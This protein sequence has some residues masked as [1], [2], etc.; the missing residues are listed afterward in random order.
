MRPFLRIASGA[1]IA[2][3][4]FYGSYDV[5]SS[6]A[7]STRTLCYAAVT[8]ADYKYVTRSTS[9]AEADRKTE[10]MAAM[11]QRAADRLLHVCMLH[12]GLY[13]K[14]GQF[15]ASMTHMMPDEI[16]RTMAACEDRASAVSF[17]VAKGAVEA[18]LQQPME[19]LFR[20]FDPTPIAAASLAQVHRAV[21]FDG[22]EVV[23]KVQY[24][25]LEVQMNADQRTLQLLSKL[26]ELCFPGCGYEWLLPEFEESMKQELDFTQEAANAKRASQMLADI[27][28]IYV[29][30]TLPQLSSSK[31]LTME[32][33]QGVK[34]TDEQAVNALQLS[35]SELVSLLVRAFSVMIF[36]GGFVHCDPHPG[37]LL[38]REDPTHCGRAQ[39]VLLDHG[40][41]RE[42]SAEFRNDYCELWYCLLTRA[43][44][45]GQ[46]AAAKLGVAPSDYDYLSLILTFR[47][48]SSLTALGSRMSN[49]ERSRLRKQMMQ[50][51]FA[52]VSGFFE[53]M[54]RDMLFVMRT[55][56]YVRS[57]NRALGGTTRNRIAVQGEHAVQGMVLANSS[58]SDSWTTVLVSQLRLTLMLWHIRL[59]MSL[60]DGFFRLL[61]L[62]RH[63]MHPEQRRRELG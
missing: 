18:A 10:A 47:P 4:G 15:M 44:S 22:Q 50:L 25:Q 35:R 60:F 16:T 52:D 43:H 13:T 11:R 5:H 39:L 58:M 2:A 63:T 51:R 37:N 49:E 55:W 9:E 42:L 24:P 1:S 30:R 26:V 48:A 12:G 32:Y 31:V 19:H 14:L 40:L 28:G 20:S 23:V 56:A 8:A 6:W 27:P 54:P 33:I 21:T 53:R 7:R 36:H 59:Y 34:I 3:V 41:Y 17:D 46:A 45:R 57:L 62:L 29:P 61:A 38:A